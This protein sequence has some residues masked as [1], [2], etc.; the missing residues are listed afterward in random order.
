MKKALAV[1]A[2][3]TRPIVKMETMLVNDLANGKSPL[4][5]AESD[6]LLY[7]L[8]FAKMRML[9]VDGR[10]IAVQEGIPFFRE[11]IVDTFRSIILENHGTIDYDE[12]RRVLPYV[13]DEIGKLEERVLRAHSNDFS[14]DHLHNELTQ[15]D[16]VVVSGGGGGAGYVYL[17]AFA[18]LEQAN[19]VPAYLIGTSIGS[20]MSIIRGFSKR[21]STEFALDIIRTLRWRDVF[22]L[23]AMESRYGLPATLRLYLR[24]ALGKHFMIGNDPL[25]MDHLPIPT[26]IVVAGIKKGGLPHDIGYY[27]GM[28]DFSGVP[29]PLQVL[30]FRKRIG[31]VYESLKEFLTNPNV[32][33][34]IVIGREGLTSTFD[35]VDAAGFSSAIP[36]VI[37]YDV[38]R[39]DPRMHAILQDLMNRNNLLRLVDGGIVANVPARAAWM[40]VEEGKI[41]RRNAFILALDCF[42]PSLNANVLFAPIQHLVQQN[43][44]RDRPYAHHLKAFHD[45]LSPLNLVP[46]Y[47]KVVQAVVKGKRAMERDMPFVQRMMEP[48]KPPQYYREQGFQHSA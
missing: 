8:A 13:I 12:L 39:N 23:A 33:Q 9:N 37:H 29:A 2:N 31:R 22:R 41:K 21:Y 11:R 18:A 19:L 30:T 24:N 35:A 5:R 4:T 38:L 7:V 17:G 1:H 20:I 36:G 40:A 15:K 44:R 45:V 14:R 27:E 16:L 28:L 32:L 43:V 26:E 6:T 47:D 48:I 10:D 3:Q 46:R 42:A 25:R 34:E